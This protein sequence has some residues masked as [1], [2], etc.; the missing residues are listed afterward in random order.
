MGSEI[1][2]MAQGKAHVFYQLIVSAMQFGGHSDSAV[3]APLS[4]KKLNS[5][6][7]ISI[8][9]HQSIAL[10]TKEHHHNPLQNAISKYDQQSLMDP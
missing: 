5:V 6:T 1:F 3:G 2:P 9:H 8:P 10:Q 7:I 4:W